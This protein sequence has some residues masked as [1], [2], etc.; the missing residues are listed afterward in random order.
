[1]GGDVLVQVHIPK[2]AGTAVA[3]W[4]WQASVDGGG[5]GFG[6][7][8]GNQGRVFDE[9]GLWEAGLKDPG[10]RALSSHDVRLFPAEIRGRRMR[11]FTILRHPL[12][13]FLSGVRYMLS[14]RAAFGVPPDVGGSTREIAEWLLSRPLGSP[15]RENSQTNHIA[16]YE[17]CAGTGGRCDPALYG[18]WDPADQAAYERERVDLAKR[19]LQ[20]FL[21]VG[22]VERLPA[23]LG[24]VRSRSTAFGLR[25]PPPETVG[26]NNT[27]TVPLDDI[28]WIQNH[29]VGRRLLDAVAAD[30]ELYRFGGQLL[31]EAL[32]SAES[33]G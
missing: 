11:Y 5:G 31:D 12:A 13:N 23:T 30:W 26:R 7:F 10:L 20:S 33:G 27:T 9:D 1:M 32:K 17:W 29:P 25:L 6:R 28:S 19:L 15:F 14:D 16:L 21:V 2:C 18:S 3:F 4:V 8:Y 22:T 24:L